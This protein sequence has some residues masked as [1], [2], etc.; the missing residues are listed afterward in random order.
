MESNKHKL[1]SIS[2]IR[3][4]RCGRNSLR[5]TSTKNGMTPA[6]PPPPTSRKRSI[7]NQPQ[8]FLNRKIV[9][10]RPQEKDSL[11]ASLE[12]LRTTTSCSG[13]IS[14]EEGVP[15]PCHASRGFG[16]WGFCYERV[17]PTYMFVILQNWAK[18]QTDCSIGEVI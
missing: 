15:L 11:A 5:Y 10:L 9:G 16:C 18:R 17:S 6:S 2:L 1:L 13:P 7:Q 12:S 4:G 14:A 8:D 3:F